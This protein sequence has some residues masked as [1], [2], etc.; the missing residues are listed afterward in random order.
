[1]K[2]C[3]CLPGSSPPVS[4]LKRWRDKLYCV[5]HYPA[6]VAE[7]SQERVRGVAVKRIRALSQKAGGK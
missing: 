5:A 4:A 2:C 1:M 7:L 3:L 6:A